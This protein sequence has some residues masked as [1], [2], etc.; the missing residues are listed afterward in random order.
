MTRRSGVLLALFCACNDPAATTASGT[1]DSSTTATDTGEPGA[2]TS[3]T[4]GTTTAPT[5]TGDPTSS[6]SGD[7]GFDPPAPVC[8]NGYLEADEECDDGNDADDDGCDS[9]CLVPCGLAGEAVALAPSAESELWVVAVAPAPDGGFVAIARQREITSDEEGMQTIGLARTRVI[10]YD[11]DAQPAW[12]VL[13]APADVRLTPVDGVVDADGHVY[14][15]ATVDGADGND[16]RAVKLDGSDGHVLWTMDKDGAEP[17]SDDSASGIALAPD[18]DVV[19]AGDVIEGPGGG[20]VW[21]GKLAAAD[22]A[23]VWTTV[24]SG[25]GNGMF[26]NDDAGRLAVAEDGSIYVGAR[27][28]VDYNIGEAVLLKFAGDGGPAE[29]VFSPLADGSVHNHGPGWV[30]VDAAGDVL[31]TAVRLQGAVPNF[32]IY[33]VGPDNELLWERALADY[34]NDGD[35]WSLDGAAFTPGG[36]VVLAGGFRVKDKQAQLEWR[37]AWVAR[38]GGDG[39]VRCRVRHRA[40]SPDLLPPDIIAYDAAVGADATA[41]LGGVQVAAGESQSWVGLF[42]P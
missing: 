12:D 21:V 6:S 30:S 14:V 8:G 16:V 37:E 19:I 26:S 27:E 2:S 34:E 31:Y 4:T 42:R 28:Y 22:G 39:E 20:D 24:W 33:K 25:E 10:R 23:E 32:W 40:P 1:D 29:W 17:T 18:G 38:L 36:E 15:A 3:T 5:T 7:P 9:A 41:Y 11:P 35:S 13:L